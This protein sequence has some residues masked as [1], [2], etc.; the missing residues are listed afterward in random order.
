MYPIFCVCGCQPPYIIFLMRHFRHDNNFFFIPN[1][2]NIAIKMS[3]LSYFILEVRAEIWLSTSS[4]LCV[5][6]FK[7]KKKF[8][9]KKRKLSCEYFLGN[10]F[11]PSTSFPSSVRH[12]MIR[13]IFNASREWKWGG[14]GGLVAT[15][16]DCKHMEILSQSL[17]EHKLHL[18]EHNGW[19]VYRHKSWVFAQ[20]KLTAQ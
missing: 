14:G 12:T 17:R 18:M 2:T 3:E 8:L 1:Q 20:C 19:W 10:C 11:P 9:F 15:L 5:C 7:E 4:Y 6:T 13:W 16:S